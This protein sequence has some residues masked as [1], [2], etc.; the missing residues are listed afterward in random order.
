M[1]YLFAF[2]LVAMPLIFM[3]DA[4]D[5]TLVPRAIFMLVVSLAMLTWIFLRAEWRTAFFQVIENKKWMFSA[6]SA[7]ISLSA[8]SLFYAINPA[9][10]LLEIARLTVLLMV[11][12]IASTLFTQAKGNILFISKMVVI[13]CGL[14]GL[15]G[16]ADIVKVSDLP[17]QDKLLY[18]ISSTAA[19]KNLLASSLFLG[20]PFCIIVLRKATLSWKCMTALILV[21]SLLLIA[22][23]QSRGVWVATTVST[24]VALLMIALIVGR[25]TL[26][27][28]ILVIT[29]SVGLLCF[30]S[31]ISVVLMKG[32]G[33]GLKVINNVEERVVSMFQ[34]H[35]VKNEHTETIN[36]RLR[37]WGNT[38]EIIKDQ[39]LMGI[40]AGNWKIVFPSKGMQGLRS[41]Q[42]AINFQRPHNDFLW[43]MSEIGLLG[44][45]AYL[46]VFLFPLVWAFRS[47]K[48]AGNTD[49]KILNIICFA[50]II[51]FC[52]ISFFDFPKERILHLS[53]LAILLSLPGPTQ[54]GTKKKI[55]V[56]TEVLKILLPV[57]L[58][59]LILFGIVLCA[60][61]LQGEILTRKALQTP[62]LEVKNKLLHQAKSVFYSMDLTGVPLAWYRGEGHFLNGDYQKALHEYQTAY[63]LHPYQIHVLNN[64]A[65]CFHVLNEKT[66]A[67]S[68][69]KKALEISPNFNNVNLNLSIINYN[70]G[71]TNSAIQYLMNC[72]TDTSNPQY[73][74][75]QKKMMLYFIDSLVLTIS[76]KEVVLVLEEIMDS[77]KWQA[78]ILHSSKR[79]GDQ[80]NISLL[81]S[82]LYKLDFL[83]HTITP[84]AAQQIANKYSVDYNV[85]H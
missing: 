21:I 1:K 55:P 4:L 58:F 85:Q 19:H 40:G 30:L 45:M 49:D 15:F 38:I 68:L 50:G 26:K 18:L 81:K 78:A 39:P 12:A 43:V 41:E 14:I 2:A 57:L 11:V 6:L 37:L 54:Q 22:V 24:V 63:Q 64:L 35:K 72:E 23:V 16:I 52:I 69:Y 33:P 46:A 10:G 44:W 7:Y 42:G 5:P 56:D 48:L 34:F 65:T 75:A 79:N 17:D 74:A 25:K 27:T 77:G 13:A 29:V 67:I 84:E 20:L 76:E 53:F 66:K 32:P 59:G 60:F 82:V 9:E 28:S 71:N 3:K 8:I 61:R 47:A 36:E 70:E 62:N 51:G 80:L 83:D 73:M 31:L